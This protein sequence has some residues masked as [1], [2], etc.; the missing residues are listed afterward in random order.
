MALASFS[1]DE[2]EDA[3]HWGELAIETQPNVPYRRLLVAACYG[4][5]NRHDK[6]REH[7]QT[8]NAFTPKFV[9]DFRAGAIDIFLDPKLDDL[10]R[11]GIAR[12]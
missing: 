10:L 2:L 7:L 4:L 11:K 3:V 1:E 12:F 6:A 5:L 8:L 9:S